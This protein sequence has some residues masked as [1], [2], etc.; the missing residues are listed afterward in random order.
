M[1]D[2]NILI[3]VK[4]KANMRNLLL[5]IIS[6]SFVGS[7]FLLI[8]LGSIHLY[9]FRIGFIF[10]V[11]CLILTIVYKQGKLR[12][13]IG[14]IKYY[15]LF[16]FLWWIYALFTLL[17]AP[18]KLDAIFDITFLSCG[19]LMIGFVVIYFNNIEYLRK[20]YKVWLVM[21]GLSIVIGL[22]NY[23]TGSHLSSSGLINAPEYKRYAP[24]SFYYNKND[25]ATYLAI[26]VPFVLTY[27]RYHATMLK[28]IVA[29]IFLL[30]C[31]FTLLV[32]DS[33]ANIIGLLL[34]LNYW[35]FFILKNRDKLKIA[36]CVFLIVVV[37]LPFY[38][39]HFQENLQNTFQGLQYLVSETKDSSTITRI[40]LIKNSLTYLVNSYGLGVGAGNVEYYMANHVLFDTRNVTNVHNWW[41]EI[42]VNY[43]IIIFFGYIV[44]FICICL[45]LYQAYFKI[46]TKE[47]K[48]ICESLIVALVIFVVG[49]V[50]PSS[51]MTFMPQWLLIAFALAFLNYYRSN[52]AID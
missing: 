14:N 4:N 38:A 18:S 10:F 13:N 43:G 23:K 45:N 42:L 39:N 46:K 35:F 28:K 6:L 31:L 8:N 25:F 29:F 50:S 32:T 15:I 20:Y 16:L 40:N 26:S 47:E 34:G 41:F 3:S 49:C 52:L 19:V 22:W 51:I 48:M 11:C 44:F 17:W 30:V 9:P 5:L 37:L 7:S 12:I 21:L 36:L 33:R 1:K 27:I 24:T 2:E